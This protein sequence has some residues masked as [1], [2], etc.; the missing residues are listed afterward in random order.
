MKSATANYAKLIGLDE[1]KRPYLLK[2]RY[3]VSFLAV[4]HVHHRWSAEELH[5]NHP[6][7]SKE[8]IDAALAYFYDHR[9]EV[10]KEIAS[11]DRAWAKG[12]AASAQP[13]REELLARLKSKS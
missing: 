11:N 13:S 12:R 8:Q 4:E 1:R 10:E 9:R 6:D 5:E 2:T 7:L 3:R